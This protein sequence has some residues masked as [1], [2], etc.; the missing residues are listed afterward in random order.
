MS[1]DATARTML[2]MTYR[3]GSST[4]GDDLTPWERASVSIELWEKA[5]D[6]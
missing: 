1:A 4:G 3:G 6:L 5:V 2:A